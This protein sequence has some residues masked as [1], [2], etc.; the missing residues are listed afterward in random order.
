MQLFDTT[1]QLVEI[2]AGIFLAANGAEK[3]RHL[4]KDFLVFEI[5]GDLP[6]HASRKVAELLLVRGIQPQ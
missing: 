1:Q 6:T 4:R 2:L 5:C 3:R